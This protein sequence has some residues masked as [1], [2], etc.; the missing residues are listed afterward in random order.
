VSQ[1]LQI[2]EIAGRIGVT[3]REAELAVR[4]ARTGRVDLITAV[5]NGRMTINAALARAKT[6][7]ASNGP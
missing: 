1:L 6:S 2:R 4:L 7:H 5:A 3:K